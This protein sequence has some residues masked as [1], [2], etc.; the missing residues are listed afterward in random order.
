MVEFIFML[1]HDDRTV[2]DALEV[3]ET[4]TGTGLRYVGFK[5][6]GAT[7][8]RQRELT[9][10]AHD[11]GMEVMLEVVSTSVDEEFESLHAARDA[12][13]DWVLGGTN[14]DLGMALLDDTG[15]RYCPFPGT[16]IGHPSELTGEIEDIARDAKVLSGHGG[17]TGV[18]LLTYRH[19]TAD[20]AELTRAVV[21][22]CS[23]PVIA[24]GSVSRVE[25]IEL[26]AAAGAWGFTIGGAIFER[27]LPGGDT[28]AGQV[29]A[30]LDITNRKT[31]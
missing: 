19:R 20:P 9:D 12:G 16:I 15:I 21:A 30:V 27:K 22:A 17:V 31:E 13:V 28:V 7:P 3:L 23:G 4:L 24:A 8:A 11:A 5:D 6:V 26:L 2:D 14:P 25:Q 10:R 29:R 1:T 18:D